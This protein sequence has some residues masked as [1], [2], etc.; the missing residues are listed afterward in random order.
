M[1]SSSSYPWDI[2]IHRERRWIKLHN[3]VFIRKLIFPESLLIECGDNYD[4][5]EEWSYKIQGNDGTILTFL[6]SKENYQEDKHLTKING[7]DDDDDDNDSENDYYMNNILEKKHFN[8]LR[9][10][11]NLLRGHNKINFYLVY[12]EIFNIDPKLK[13]QDGG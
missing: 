5:E 12:G 3:C 13:K 9:K 2:N 4:D 6:L 8:T 7:S 1:S 11:L 10:N